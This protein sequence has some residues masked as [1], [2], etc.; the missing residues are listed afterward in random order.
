MK[1]KRHGVDIGLSYT[2]EHSGRTFVHYIAEAKQ[3]ML[4]DKIVNA[5]FYSLLLDTSTGTGNVDNEVLLV[6][7]CDHDRHDE[8]VHTRMSYFKVAGLK[9]GK[10]EGLF[11]LAQDT[12]KHF[13][14]QAMDNGNCT[15]LAQMGHL[16]I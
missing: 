8:K 11:E 2:N 15:S 5:K 3:Q 16:L 7:W 12:L 1:L 13:G 10:G 9:S 14:I 6:V 4:V